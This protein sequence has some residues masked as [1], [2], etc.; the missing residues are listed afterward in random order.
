MLNLSITFYENVARSKISSNFKGDTISQLNVKKRFDGTI[1]FCRA[2]TIQYRLNYNLIEIL[3]KVKTT[4]PQKSR[5]VHNI[6]NK[7]D[8]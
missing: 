6:Q 3:L 8:N 7:I 5:I 1:D 2:H 4:E